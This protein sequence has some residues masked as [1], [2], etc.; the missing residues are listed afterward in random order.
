LEL[1]LGIEIRI[2]NYLDDHN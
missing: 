2:R 1:E